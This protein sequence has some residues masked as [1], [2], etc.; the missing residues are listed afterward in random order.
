M[1][2]PAEQNK[3]LRLWE[4]DQK[5]K[6]KKRNTDPANKLTAS[7]IKQIKKEGGHAFR[8]NV[9]GVRRKIKGREVWTKSSTQRGASDIQAVYKGQALYIEVKWGDDTQSDDQKEFQNDVE[10]AGGIYIIAE[11]GQQW[12]KLWQ[13]LKKSFTN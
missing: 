11:T 4:A 5:K 6:K 12:Q 7:I 8:V 2:T 10:R 13:E 9:Q 3:L 1:T